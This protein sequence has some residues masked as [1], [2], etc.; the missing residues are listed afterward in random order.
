MIQGIEASLRL[1]L[2]RTLHRVERL[3]HIRKPLLVVAVVLVVPVV[4]VLI[5]DALVVVLQDARQIA[6]LAKELAL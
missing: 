6:V 4:R 3:P 1:P 5:E 2:E